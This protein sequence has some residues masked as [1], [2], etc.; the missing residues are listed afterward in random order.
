MLDKAGQEQIAKPI[1]KVKKLM[2]KVYP[3]KQRRQA[4]K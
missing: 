1:E 2:L 3:V 4:T